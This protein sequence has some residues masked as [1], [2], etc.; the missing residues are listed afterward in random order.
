MPHKF[1]TVKLKSGKSKRRVHDSVTGRILKWVEVEDLDEPEGQF[2]IVEWVMHWEYTDGSPSGLRNF[3]IRLRV[4]EG[5]NE[6]DM[7]ELGRDIMESWVSEE[8][9]TE[10]NFSFDRKGVDFIRYDEYE[11]IEYKI[12]D[13]ARPQY[14]YPK[15][16]RWGKWKE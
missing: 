1:Y 6:S 11:D 2:K 12:I 14:Q 16:A 7:E 13:N 8:L 5:R 3:E 15:R 9:V 4:A 10:S